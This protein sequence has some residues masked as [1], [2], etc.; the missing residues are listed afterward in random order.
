[1]PKID[2][3]RIDKA[4]ADFSGNGGSQGGRGGHSNGGRGQGCGVV[5]VVNPTPLASRRAIIKLD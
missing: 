2:Q 5:M 4:K 3:A 1:M